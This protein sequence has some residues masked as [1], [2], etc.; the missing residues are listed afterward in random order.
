MNTVTAA[1][2]EDLSIMIQG[3]FVRLHTKVTEY[4]HNDSCST[5]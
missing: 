3:F 5:R 2:L 4:G 1:G